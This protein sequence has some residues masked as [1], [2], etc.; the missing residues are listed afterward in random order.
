M[1]LAGFPRASEA[2]MVRGES[3]GEIFLLRAVLVTVH[4]CVR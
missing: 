3:G 2:G 1:S 4:L